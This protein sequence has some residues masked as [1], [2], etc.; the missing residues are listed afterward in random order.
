MFSG[1]EGINSKAAPGEPGRLIYCGGGEIML[2]F[3]IGAICGAVFVVFIE[4]LLM[5][6]SDDEKPK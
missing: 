2:M 1:S 5:A 6:G 4:A 3:C